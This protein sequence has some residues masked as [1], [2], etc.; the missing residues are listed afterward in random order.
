M[1][2]ENR[3]FGLNKKTNAEKEP[4]SLPTAAELRK[5]LAKVSKSDAMTRL[6]SLFDARTFVELNAYTRRSF[7]ERGTGIR[8]AEFE[9]VIC[10][11][12]AINGQPVFAFAQDATRM[13]GA[14][15]AAHAKKICQL[16][17][18]AIKNGAPVV[19]FF[20]CAG[21]DI[22]EGVDALA[23]YGHI[24]QA[25]SAASGVIP[26]VAVVTGNCL[27]SFSAIAAMFDAVVCTK[28]SHLYVTPPS[29]NGVTGGQ[30]PLV[31]YEAADALEGVA[32]ARRLLSFLPQN[33]GEGV[34]V[35]TAQ[36][37]LN[38]TLEGLGA[39]EEVH[40]I[41]AAISDRGEYVELG[42][43]VAPELVTALTV[44]GGVRCG[45]LASNYVV[46]E[47]RLSA[48]GARKAAR[49]IDLCDA[50]SLPL[51]TLANSA[52]FAIDG[53]NERT[54][55]AAELGKLAMAYTRA[56]NV[57]VTVVLGRAIGGAF[58]LLGSKSVGADIA[59]AYEGAEIGA[60]NAA[61]TVAFAMNDQVT[62]SVSREELEEQ[63]RLSLASPVA[64][65]S[66]GEIDDII[67]MQE[68]RARLCS[69]L[70]LLAAKG[71]VPGGRHRILPL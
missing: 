45:V 38:R 69:S 26:Q 62:T 52:G 48:A 7:S 59:Y 35:S 39:D 16:Y 43:P 41:L 13:K 22:F 46:N 1:K 71:T 4:V 21:A 67:G 57:K 50:F 31:T 32:Y 9:G 25:V 29:L 60:L 68:L 44:I 37:D 11:Y 23:A 40:A 61:A 70:L 24:M 5:A 36:D 3:E 55:F 33:S 10:G 19:G 63:W 28:D 47:G 64:A 65:A 17:D 2:K 54:P 53:E 42:S 15:D 12:G 58:T 8:E 27:G 66:T 18:M 30:E 6:R 56:T 49:F 14:M 34:S 20:D 51:I